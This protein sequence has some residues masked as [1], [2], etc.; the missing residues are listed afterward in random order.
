[1][2]RERGAGIV[3]VRCDHAQAGYWFEWNR[4]SSKENWYGGSNGGRKFKP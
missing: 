4:F 3:M 1:M 2:S